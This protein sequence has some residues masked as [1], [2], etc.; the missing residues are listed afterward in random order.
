MSPMGM[1]M[2]DESRLRPGE[3]FFS[4]PLCW[5][6][7]GAVLLDLPPAEQLLHPGS[8]GMVDVSCAHLGSSHVPIVRL[9]RSLS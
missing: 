3:S 7:R 2:V 4:A 5:E 1:Q 8:A 9:I 6:C